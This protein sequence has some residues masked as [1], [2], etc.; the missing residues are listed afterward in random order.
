M[1]QGYKATFWLWQGSL[2][3]W[4]GVLHVREED[5]SSS[6]LMT[7]RY[8]LH[9]PFW[10]CKPWP[11]SM[12]S[13]VG[14]GVHHLMASMGGDIIPSAKHMCSFQ[15]LHPLHSTWSLHPSSVDA[16]TDF[17]GRSHNFPLI[18]SKEVLLAGHWVITQPL[19]SCGIITSSLLSEVGLHGVGLVHLS[20]AW[21]HLY[22]REYQPLTQW[23][24][25]FSG[26][27]MTIC[28]GLS[29]CRRGHCCNA[30]CHLTCLLFPYIPDLH[31]SLKGIGLH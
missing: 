23:E 5:A 31:L 17:Y 27:C 20:H 18:H 1:Q 30:M 21:R 19:L 15:C 4:V 16:P 25:C 7:Q 14:H 8:L 3:D 2:F 24:V 22:T 9:P 10:S 11:S 6:I 12:R 28:I 26:G 13:C 29:L